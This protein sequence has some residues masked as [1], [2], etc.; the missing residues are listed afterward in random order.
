MSRAV[1]TF[2]VAEEDVEPIPF[3][4]EFLPADP[5]EDRRVEHFEAYGK[6]PAGAMVAALK[7]QRRRGK[8]VDSPDSE[9]LMEFFALSMPPED[10]TRL[11]ALVDS[12]DWMIEFSVLAQIFGWLLE[13][14]AERP[15][16]RSRRSS[17]TRPVDGRTEQSAVIELADSSVVETSS[18]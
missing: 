1:K 17:S 2:T 16:R 18:S 9:A 11:A 8:V 3:D 6:A 15:T 13:E 5:D 10:Y 7:V 12:P 4:L 14:Q